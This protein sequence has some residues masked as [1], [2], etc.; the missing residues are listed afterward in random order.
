MTYPSRHGSELE[1]ILV[2]VYGQPE[3]TL[4]LQSPLDLP[5]LTSMMMTLPDPVKFQ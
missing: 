1:I 5:V 2:P 4:M 3:E